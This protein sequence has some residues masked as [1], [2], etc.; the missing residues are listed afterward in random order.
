[1]KIFVLT[2]FIGS[3]LETQS[4][5][6]LTKRPLVYEIVLRFILKNIDILLMIVLYTA[7]CNRI[8]LYH[9]ILLALFAVYIMYQAGFRKRFIFLLYF[10]IF[11]ASIK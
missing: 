6:G 1:L 10:M 9:E 5:G 3:Q 8:D 4:F 11:I 7:G 2:Y